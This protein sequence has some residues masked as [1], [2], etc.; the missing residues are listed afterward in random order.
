M[1]WY[2]IWHVLQKNLVVERKLAGRGS[3]DE[4]RLAMHCKPER[5]GERLVEIHYSVSSDFYFYVRV[6]IIKSNKSKQ[7]P[8]ISKENTQPR[9]ST[10]PKPQLSVQIWSRVLIHL[11]WGAWPEGLGA[12]ESVDITACGGKEEGQSWQ[13]PGSRGWSVDCPQLCVI[14]VLVLRPLLMWSR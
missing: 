4:A 7:N 13:A 11:G 3:I 8:K 5:L 1:K 10:K 6:S 9:K 12:E 14:S 2:G